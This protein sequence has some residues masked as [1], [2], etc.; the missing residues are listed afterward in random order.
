M[1]TITTSLNKI[2]NT[3]SGNKVNQIKERTQWKLIEIIDNNLDL[4]DIEWYEILKKYFKILW[5][6]LRHMTL[7]WIIS[8]SL[9]TG[10]F[11]ESKSNFIE[12]VPHTLSKLSWKKFIWIQININ[13]FYK[14]EFGKV[15]IIIKN[16]TDLLNLLKDK[17]NWNIVLYIND[18]EKIWP[19]F[20]SYK[21]DHIHINIKIIEN[22][23]CELLDN[24]SRNFIVIWKVNDLSKL[25][26]CLSSRFGNKYNFGNK[27][28]KNFIN[29]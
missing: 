3:I 14:S 21:W 20:D 25:N 15:E 17:Y 27:E 9:I 5:T 12:R 13:E 16:I 19:S 8:T 11:Q 26:C 1:D 6:T 28:R 23:L 10:D 7:E 18:I 24:R 2:N 29:I 22:L 4:Q